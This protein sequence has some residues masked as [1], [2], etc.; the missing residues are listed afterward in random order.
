MGT[1]VSVIIPVYKVEKYI[2]R[3]LDALIGQTFKDWEVICVN[4]GSPDSSRDIILEYVRRDSRIRLIDKSNGGVSSARNRGVEEAVGEY[5]LFLD[6]DDFI[7]PQTLE[8][9]MALGRKNS[10]DVVTWYKD[11]SY[12]VKAII[13]YKMG[14]DTIAYRP[15]G[16]YKVYDP[17]TVD[18]LTTDCLFEHL[19]ESSVMPIAYPVKHFYIWRMIVRRSLIQDIRFDTAISFG[20]EF[21]WWSALLLKNPRVTI[22]SLPL[23]Y[24][25]PNFGSLE[26]SSTRVK[27]VYY[28]I[29]GLEKSAAILSSCDNSYMKEC[30][31][32]ECK[33]PVIR[34][35]ISSKLGRL[36][37][38]GADISHIIDYLQILWDKGIFD[39]PVT[40][41][42]VKARETIARL[43]GR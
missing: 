12:R 16:F 2:S 21:P 19:S 18:S 36:K 39:D 37:T 42:D 8:I 40:S 23:Y 22:T 20:E 4:D 38:S 24:Y 32:R 28:W 7:H 3:T 6:S 13:R 10:S 41:R 33:W 27:K 15:Q 1:A 31:V 17:E 14:M 35:H 9:A 26:F 30:W 11:S 43:I 29:L 5:V 34:I 25:Y